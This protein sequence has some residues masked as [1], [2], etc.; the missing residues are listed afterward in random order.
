M[1]NP[2][3]VCSFRFSCL[4]LPGALVDCQMK[5]FESRLHHVFQGGYVATHEIDLDGEERKICHNCVDEL[6]MGGKPNK[7]K[8][9]QHSTM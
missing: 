8:K 6:W 3:T 1:A 9:M 7:L 4:F 2:K 5:G